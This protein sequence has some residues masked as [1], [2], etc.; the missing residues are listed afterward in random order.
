MQQ[1]LAHKGKPIKIILSWR[2]QKPLWSTALLTWESQE[3]DFLMLARTQQRFLIFWQGWFLNLSKIGIVWNIQ[4]EL[5]LT[6]GNP[7]LSGKVVAVVIV[8]SEPQGC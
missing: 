8:V 6:I 2:E 5:Y 1:R 3:I 4:S 7:V